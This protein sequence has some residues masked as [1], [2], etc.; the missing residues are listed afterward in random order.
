MGQ[1]ACTLIAHTDESAV[2]AI[3]QIGD[4]H[5]LSSSEHTEPHL[6]SPVTHE[7]YTW[8]SEIQALK[9]APSAWRLR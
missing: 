7:P 5:L 1:T 4:E 9:D 3:L 2:A 8:C 6:L